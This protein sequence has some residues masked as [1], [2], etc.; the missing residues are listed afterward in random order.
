MKY[1]AHKIPKNGVFIPGIAKTNS[2]E[3]YWRKKIA[4]NKHD[5]V[6]VIQLHIQRSKGDDW[7]QL[8]VPKI[9]EYNKCT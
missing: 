7:R 5:F 6:I 8:T 9:E 1:V 2:S 3:A 4:A